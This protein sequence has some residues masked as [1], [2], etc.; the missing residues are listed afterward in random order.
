MVF[1]E[2]EIEEEE[3]DE[4]ILNDLENLCYPGPYVYKCI[5]GEELN[6]ATAAYYLLVNLKKRLIQEHRTVAINVDQLM[7]DSSDEVEK[8]I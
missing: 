7:N 8:L 6:Y 2:I 1:T 5:R 3:V 4:D